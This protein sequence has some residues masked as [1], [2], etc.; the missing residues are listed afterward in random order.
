MKRRILIAV[1]GGIAV[2]K[3][4]QLVSNLA[5]EH[6][7]QVV[8][9]EH[10]EEFMSPLT[11]ETLTH[12]PVYRKM[13]GQ[14]VKHT[15][16]PHIDLAKWAEIIVIAPATANIIAKMAAGL[17]DDLL[18]TLLLAARCPVLLCP[19][20]NSF[21]LGHEATQANLQL[22]KKR[23]IHVLEAAEGFLAC[24]DV[25][26]G[27]LPAPE[28]IAARL[29]A[30]LDETDARSRD[31]TGLR[32]TV[33]AGPTR[34]ALDPVRF[35]SN[36]SSGRMGYALA[37]EACRRGAEVH[38]I[39]GPVSLAAPEGVTLHPVVS[40]RDMLSAVQELLPQSD[41]LIKAAAVGDYRPAEEAQEKIKKSG[42]DLVLRLVRNPDILAW[43]GTHANKGT[44]ICGFAMETR[45]LLANARQ[46]LASKNCDLLVA[47]SLRQEGAGFGVQTNIATLLWPD[48]EEALPLMSKTALADRILDECRLLYKEKNAYAHDN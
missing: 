16:V 12:R 2:F 48:R 26:S 27:K 39:S 31:L 20:M 34:E 35:I 23:G 14:E 4:A 25:G 36:H 29:F 5:K 41:I 21:M 24:G 22:L 1:T 37:A 18:S 30:I 3:T 33:T 45:D 38:L 17:A 46:K 13:F 40:A 10:A 8:M 47:N 43:A 42:T 15:S 11:F 44:V 32:I 19:A 9:S 6:E 28:E 7:V